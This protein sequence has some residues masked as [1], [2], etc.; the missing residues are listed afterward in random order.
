MREY[1]HL[2]VNLTPAMVDQL[3][4]NHK[5]VKAHLS[6]MRAE[7]SETSLALKTMVNEEDELPDPILEGTA[8]K[9]IDGCLQVLKN[10][11]TLKHVRHPWTQAEADLTELRRRQLRSNRKDGP[12]LEQ[13]IDSIQKAG[14]KVS[15][16]KGVHRS[17][18]KTSSLLH[19]ALAEAPPT[20]QW[21]TPLTRR[22]ST[23]PPPTRP[24]Q[25]LK[26]LQT[27]I[28]EDF[29]AYKRLPPREFGPGAY[30]TGIEAAVRVKEPSKPSYCFIAVSGR[31]STTVNLR[32]GHEM[33]TKS[34]MNGHAVPNNY[35]DKQKKLN[36][37]IEFH[38]PLK[39]RVMKLPLKR[40][41][42]IERMHRGKHAYTRR[43]RY[44]GVNKKHLERNNFT[45]STGNLQ[46]LSSPAGKLL[47]DHGSLFSR[48]S[49]TN[50]RGKNRPSTTFNAFN[51]LSHAHS[52]P[53]LSRAFLTTA[54]ALC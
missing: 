41:S 54:P 53:S 13:K 35:A 37:I 6:T 47:W 23:V 39:S 29:D 2:R 1:H 46:S 4:N 5:N 38:S 51:A 11:K 19:T 10:D 32:R 27:A 40:I 28:T 9:Y 21:C 52:S 45:S 34:W 43:K 22:P 3:E 15:D 8:T 33:E 42:S 7:L 36:S 14:Q 20:R 26:S 49:Q 48:G 17:I 44:G 31:P 30:E 16:L 25:A 12:T 24:M 50:D 18:R